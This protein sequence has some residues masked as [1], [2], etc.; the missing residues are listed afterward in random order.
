[1]KVVAIEVLWVEIEKKNGSVCHGD[2]TQ[3]IEL[4]ESTF[5]PVLEYC[6]GHLICVIYYSPTVTTVAHWIGLGT[7]LISIFR[8]VYQTQPIADDPIGMAMQH[9]SRRCVPAVTTDAE[10]R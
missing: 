10:H 3:I 9:T 2:E 1:V 7:V 5:L 4:L 8:S 6:T